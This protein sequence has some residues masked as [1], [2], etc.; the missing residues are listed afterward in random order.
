MKMVVRCLI[1][2]MMACALIMIK[3]TFGQLAI[4]EDELNT[5]SSQAISTTQISARE[6][7]EDRL[8]NV[9]NARCRVDNSCFNSNEDYLNDLK[10][11]LKA[12]ITT[13]SKYEIKV[14]GIDYEKGLLDVEICCTYKQITGQEKTLSTRKTS[15][16]EVIGML[17]G[18]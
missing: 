2:S 9:E 18:D 3:I 12:L 6:Q 17:K 11:N 4:R 13:N 5:I 7:I 15:I 16:V 8:Y 10:R 1:I 14:Y